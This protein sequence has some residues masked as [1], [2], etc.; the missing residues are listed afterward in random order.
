LAGRRTGPYSPHGAGPYGAGNPYAQYL[1]ELSVKNP[2]EHEACFKEA[3][4]KNL[5]REARWKFM[6]E[7]MKKK[8][9]AARPTATGGAGR[10]LILL[11]PVAVC[12][13]LSCAAAGE[14]GF[15]WTRM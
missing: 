11:L 15:L 4:E 5:Y 8:L 13:R 1:N 14:G 10:P 12:P 9:L 7:C 2:E 6:I 3:N